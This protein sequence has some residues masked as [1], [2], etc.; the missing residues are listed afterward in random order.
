[1]YEVPYEG[2]AFTFKDEHLGDEYKALPD[3]EKCESYSAEQMQEAYRAGMQAG[4]E[5][6]ARGLVDAANKVIQEVV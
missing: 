6:M 1:M 2:W 5:R 3:D 4:A